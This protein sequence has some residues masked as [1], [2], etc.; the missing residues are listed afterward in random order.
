MNFENFLTRLNEEVVQVILGPQVIQALTVLDSELTRL[1][2]LRTKLLNI[3]SPAELLLDKRLR[4]ELLDLLRP[5]EATDLADK[6]GVAVGSDIFNSLKGVQFNTDFQRHVLFRFFEIPEEEL[7]E[8]P[9]VSNTQASCQYPLFKH[10]RKAVRELKPLLSSVPKKVMLHMPT[11][12]GKTRTA[13]NFIAEHLRANEP[14][15]VIWLAHTEELCEQAAQE[16][17]NAWQCIGNRNLPVIRYW[18]TSKED[19]KGQQD[20]FIVAGL[21]KLYSLVKRDVIYVS[22]IAAKTSLV[23]MDEAHMAIAPTYQRILEVF[24]SF[25]VAMLGLSATP[26]RTWNNPEEDAKLADFFNHKKVIL[27]VDGYINPVKY[28]EDEKYLAKVRNNPLLCQSGFKLTH[29]DEKYLQE[30]LQLPPATLKRLSEDQIRNALIVSKIEELT[31]RH[32]RIIVFALTV[33]HAHTFAA[34][35]QARGVSAFTITSKTS[36]LQRKRLI[37]HFKSDVEESLVL[38]NYG[39]LTT[40]FDAPQTSC[41]VIS[42]P[43]DSLVLYSQ[44]VG[45]AIRG[46]R[47]GGNDEAEIVTVVDTNLPG[48]NHVAMAFLNWIS[49]KEKE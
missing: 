42:R 27:E 31:T 45:R 38:C 17:E 4:N 24:L 14:T 25:N 3:Y 46:T 39:I 21:N 11:G 12:S 8:E 18:S 20:A 36:S 19:I 49:D 22:A 5:Y 1:S 48:F 23:V 28:L 34:I 29:K 32:Q 37:E 26:G 15:L 13:M 35:L 9:F 41:A 43:T 33:E 40:G 7:D 44:M 16:F 30:H 6:L 2:T 47:A 10:Q